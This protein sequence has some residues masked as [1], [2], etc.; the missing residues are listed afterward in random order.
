MLVVQFLATAV[1]DSERDTY[2]RLF[3]RISPTAF[4]RSFHSWLSSLVE[5]LGAQ[6]VPI[7]G[8]KFNGSYDRNQQQS[9]LHVVSA[10]GA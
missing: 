4:E 2:R 5:D 9:S 10:W 7:D 6:V 1:W 3:E 8:K